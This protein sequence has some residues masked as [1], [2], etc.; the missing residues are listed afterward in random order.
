M[1]RFDYADELPFGPLPWPTG[2]PAPG[3][4]PKINLLSGRW[5]TV[6]G[7]DDVTVTT[8]PKFSTDSE[9]KVSSDI[10]QVTT[11]GILHFESADISA[12]NDVSIDVASV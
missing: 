8:E 5:A 9:G 7:D 10:F 11:D 6:S 4:V 2:F 12:F 3:Y 1:E